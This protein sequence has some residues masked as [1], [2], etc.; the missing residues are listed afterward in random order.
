MAIIYKRIIYIILLASLL[1]I[2]R[3]YLLKEPLSLIKEKRVIETIKMGTS[4]SGKIEFKLPNDLTEPLNITIDIVKYL[5]L[6]QEPLII[7]ARDEVD[8]NNGRIAGSINIPYDYYED[9]EY[10]LDDIDLEKILIIYCS[11]GE[12]SLS[13]DLAD[14]LMQDKGF[15]NVL[16]YE[17]GWPEWKNSGNPVE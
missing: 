7:D 6:N 15:F 12:C 1:G 9:Y 13:I 3:N 8:F 5:R 14:Y 17:G 16:I 2:L 4:D 10:Q 11:G